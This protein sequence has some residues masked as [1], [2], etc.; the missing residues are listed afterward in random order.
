MMKTRTSPKI[1]SYALIFLLAVLVIVVYS[2]FRSGANSEG[3]LLGMSNLIF[4]RNGIFASALLALAAFCA[5]SVASANA[6]QPGL[7]KK[8]ST[9]AMLNG[10][11]AENSSPERTTTL[12][13]RGLG[14]VVDHFGQSE[15]WQNIQSKH[16]THSSIFSANASDY[17]SD[18]SSRRALSRSRIGS[19][20]RYGAGEAVEYWPIP[21]IAVAPPKHA[22]NPFRAGFSIAPARQQASLAF[23]TFVWQEDVNDTTSNGAL[24]DLFAFFDANPDVPAALVFCTDGMETRNLLRKPGSGFTPNVSSVPQVFDNTVVL[25]VARPDRVDRLIRPFVVPTPDHVDTRETQF[26]IVKL[27]NLYWKETKAFDDDYKKQQEAK[28]NNAQATPHT[29]TTAWWQSKLPQLWTEVENRGPGDFKKSPWLPVRWTSWQLQQ[30]DESPVLGY[31]GRPV[32]SDLKDEHGNSLKP[33]AQAAAL[34]TG[35]QQAEQKAGPTGKPQR[36]FF[37]T[38]TDRTWSIPLTQALHGNSDAISLSDPQEGYD[39]GYR[40]GNTG[41]S[42]ELVQIGLAL[43]AAY[44]DGKPSAAISVSSHGYADISIV[45]PPTAGEKSKNESHRGADPFTYRVPD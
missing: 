41:V 39:I 23:Q 20:F 45:T 31:L 36:V 1:R 6:A 17:P 11:A 22:E 19:A 5:H 26:D 43:M 3:D 34:Q 4:V 7:D 18:S 16:E 37:D 35:W 32:R 13:V 25:L 27:W 12:Q 40:L 29:M 33:A 28:G 44:Q 14:I 8:G 38:S 30:F 21:V 9:A 10:G 24:E 15:I 2:M 42:S